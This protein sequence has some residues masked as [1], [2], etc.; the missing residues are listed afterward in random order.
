MGTMRDIGP[1]PLINST[2]DKGDEEDNK[3]LSGSVSTVSTSSTADAPLTPTQEDLIDNNS[4]DNTNNNNNNEEQDI[5]SNDDEVEGS[6]TNNYNN[7]QQV[8]K[9]IV[10][11]RSWTISS[12]H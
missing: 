4:D 10:R 6:F 3:S 8:Q 11:S 1:P 9:S 7:K 12:H 5:K 2:L